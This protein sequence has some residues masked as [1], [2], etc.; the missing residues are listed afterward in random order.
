M[1]MDLKFLCPFFMVLVFLRGICGKDLATS[2]DVDN[3]L[4]CF[5]HLDK[6]FPLPIEPRPLQR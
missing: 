5:S 3:C 2:W 6:C 4:I 1:I